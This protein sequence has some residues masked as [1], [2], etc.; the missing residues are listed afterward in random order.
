MPSILSSTLGA[1]SYLFFVALLGATDFAAGLVS[2]A[3]SG[4]AAFLGATLGFTSFTGFSGFAASTFLPD[5]FTTNFLG[6]ALAGLAG[7]AG[8]LGTGALLVVTYFLAMN[9]III[10]TLS[11]MVDVNP[12]NNQIQEE[13]GRPNNFVTEADKTSG[14][15]ELWLLG[16]RKVSKS[17]RRPLNSKARIEKNQGAKKLSNPVFT[18][19][20]RT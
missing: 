5:A 4:L 11:T 9:A 20:S 16:D 18:P 15:L 10:N 8:A 3:F 13:E 17:R 14:R 2:A 7:V 19:V 1:A 6:A 12:G